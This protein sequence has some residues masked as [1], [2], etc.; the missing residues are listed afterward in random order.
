[1]ITKETWIRVG[2]NAGGFFIALIGLPI[3]AVYV[4]NITEWLTARSPGTAVAFVLACGLAWA[5]VVRLFTPDNVRGR[6]G[7]I[8]P[9]FVAGLVVAIALV[10]IYLFA[11]LSFALLKLGAVDYRFASAPEAHL[12]DLADAYVWYFFDLIPLLDVNEALGWS[13][14]M[15]LT[16][17][18][19]GFIVL[20]FRIIVVFQLFGLARRLIAA[21]REPRPA[22]REGNEAGTPELAV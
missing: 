14:D 19:K 9:G 18:A 21:S 7:T 15:N 3:A 10:W 20:L 1:M 12:A 22:K 16:G 5:L 17:G 13:A 6:D 4:R 2:E 8:V 11:S